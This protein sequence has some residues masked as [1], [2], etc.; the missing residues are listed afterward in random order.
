MVELTCCPYCKGDFD[1]KHVQCQ[2]CKVEIK[3]Q[4]KVNRF[5]MFDPEQLYFIEVFLKTEGN[6]KLVEKELG[7]S[8]PT[9]KNRL[10]KIIQVLGYDKEPLRTDDRLD[11]LNKLSSGEME[12]SE[13]L[14]LL[15]GQQ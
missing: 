5:H 13:A 4:F 7:I 1:I 12:V 11:I 10:Q 6:I 9:V 3:G 15:G 8:Y 14:E 2:G